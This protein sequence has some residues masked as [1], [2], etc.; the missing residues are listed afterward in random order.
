M[1]AGAA[2]R[3]RIRI[4]TANEP[5][6][7]PMGADVIVELVGEDGSV[8][9]LDGVTSL[10]MEVDSRQSRVYADI[11][12]IG[13]ELDVDALALPHERYAQVSVDGIEG[14]LSVLF[15]KAVPEGEWHEKIA[16][17]QR[18]YPS[19][20]IV[21]RPPFDRLQ[22]W[23]SLSWSATI[24]DVDYAGSMDLHSRETHEH[25]I[26]RRLARLLEDATEM[27]AN[28]SEAAICKLGAYPRPIMLP[29]E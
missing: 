5:G 1:G 15:N 6:T 10:R 17:L 29:G 19:F 28:R 20:D 9:R 27:L 23:R 25:T 24:D 4:R 16:N 8:E 7:I 14:V 22:Q 12:V 11:R 3:R 18:T 2:G 21:L 26:G 13:P